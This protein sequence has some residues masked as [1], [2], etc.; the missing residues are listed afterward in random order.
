MAE[1][2]IRVKDKIGADFYLDCQCTKRGDVIIAAIDGQ[3]WGKEELSLPFYRILKHTGV[4]VAE[5]SQFVAPELPVDPANPSRTLKRR[6]F[7]MNIDLATLPAAFKTWLADDTRKVPILDV[8]SVGL[9]K[10]A[11]LALK[12]DKGVTADPMVIGGNQ[13]VIG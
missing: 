13:A 3:V 4:T 2:L 12:T 7:K 5:A 8:S 11:L 9:G 1:L 6:Q 10:P